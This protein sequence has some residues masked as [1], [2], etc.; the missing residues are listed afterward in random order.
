[1]AAILLLPLFWGAVGGSIYG[2]F[3]IDV[4][5]WCFMDYI[6][7]MSSLAPQLFSVAAVAGLVGGGIYSIA[8]MADMAIQLKK[9]SNLKVPLETP[10]VVPQTSTSSEAASAGNHSVPTSNS[11]VDQNMA[12]ATAI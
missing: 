3:S 12:S 9:L 8:G 2:C 4:S 5:A 1:M 10:A 11:D 7:G 6:N